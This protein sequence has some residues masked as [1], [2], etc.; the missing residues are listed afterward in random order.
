[1][2]LRLSAPDDVRLRRRGGGG[3]IVLSLSALTVFVGHGDHYEWTCSL[4]GTAGMS[5][6][7]LRSRNR[8]GQ[9]QNRRLDFA[10]WQDGF[11]GL[12]AGSPSKACTGTLFGARDVFAAADGLLT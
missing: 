7:L 9:L 3:V 11:F 4:C 1:M 2:R 5:W 12:D 10:L 8:P 6:S